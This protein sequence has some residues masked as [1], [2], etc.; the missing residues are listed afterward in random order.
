MSEAQENP[1]IERIQSSGYQSV[2]AVTGGGV[3]AIHCM[4]AHPGASRFVLDI[5][6]P[7][8]SEALESFLGEHPESSCS[9]DTV[10]KLAEAAFR[11]AAKSSGK[12]LAVACTAALQTNR[13]RKGED[14]AYI[15]IQSADRV[16]CER[17]NVP[18][19]ARSQQD[20]QLSGQIL[21][22]IADFIRDDDDG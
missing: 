15:C 21:T 8:S 16:V 20:A 3:A 17:F 5:R 18:P 11:Q 4:L 12:P 22:M 2:W 9:S 1:L 19:G 13:E 7:Y 10:R 14:R 6:I